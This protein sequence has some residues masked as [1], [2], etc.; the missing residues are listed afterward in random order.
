MEPLFGPLGP[1][2]FENSLFLNVPE[3]PAVLVRPLP[4]ST[5]RCG[6]ITGT[7]SPKH[8]EIDS[9]RPVLANFRRISKFHG[10][11]LPVSE[12]FWTVQRQSMREI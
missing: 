4:I 7:N 5:R 8:A 10:V 6:Q 1:V 11:F 3:L 12:Q 9:K 2:I